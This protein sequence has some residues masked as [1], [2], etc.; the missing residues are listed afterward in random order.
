[1]NILDFTRDFPDEQSCEEYLKSHRER[2][3]VY[4]KTCCSYTN[5]YWFGTK[6]CF[7]CSKCRR[8]TSLKA[9]TVMES[10]NLS[11]HTWFAAF[12]L[13]WATKKG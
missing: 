2:E 11:L 13:M 5:H 7:E 4:C 12:L 10:S 3:G 8:R 9:G 6:K 1:M